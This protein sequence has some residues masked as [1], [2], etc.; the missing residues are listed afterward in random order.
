MN[1]VRA[2]QAVSER[3]GNTP[4]ICRKCYVHPAV[5]EAY[6]AGTLADE[7]ATSRA[8]PDGLTDEEA[9]ALTLLRARTAV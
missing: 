7:L 6:A 3:L 8:S 9:A 4:A 5:F 1:V 2:V